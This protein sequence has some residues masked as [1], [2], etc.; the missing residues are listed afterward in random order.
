MGMLAACVVPLRALAGPGDGIRLGEVVIHPSVQTEIGYQSNVHLLDRPGDTD[1]PDDW[2]LRIVPQVKAEKNGGRARFALHALYDWRKYA[3]NTEL[4]SFQDFEVGAAVNVNE[5]RPLSLALENRTRA[6]SRPSELELY[7]RHHR[8]SNT[9]RVS[10]MYKPGT[11]L[12][13]KPSAF[14]YYD[15]FTASGSR[16]VFAE[17][18][19]TGVGADARWAFLSRTVL[20]FTGEGGQ[21]RYTESIP[22]PQA[23]RDVNTGS[24]WWHGEGGLVGQVRPKI[25]IALKLGY[26]QAVYDDGESLNDVRGITALA[27]V[28]WIPRATNHVTLAYDR[29]FRDVYFTNFR[30]NDRV[31]ASYRHLLAGVWLGEARGAF[32][33]QTYS[34]PFERRD[35]VART[36]LSMRRVLREWADVGLSY[37]YEQR[38][39]NES[40]VAFPN[41]DP[42]SDY[43][44]HRGMLTGNIQW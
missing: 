10:T 33:W 38:W 42:E 39:S 44:T 21:V 5:E 32:A 43:V 36:D 18:H 17:K 37:G 22:L 25:N 24:Y 30:I 7:G 26:G 6:Q 41:A 40:G 23:G 16:D 20:A 14:W 31:S 4:D 2:W 27:K 19:T 8:L 15:K 1:S 13:V 9:A 35:Q 12:E 34:E 29:D 11:A 28:E 3:Y